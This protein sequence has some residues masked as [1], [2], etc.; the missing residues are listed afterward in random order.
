M[1]TSARPRIFLEIAI[2]AAP[3]GSLEFELFVDA[4]P[5]TCLGSPPGRNLRQSTLHQSAKGV[6]TCTPNSSVPAFEPESTTSKEANTKGLL[7]AVA[8]SSHF[9]ITLGPKPDSKALIFGHMTQGGELL[10]RMA[11]TNTLISISD[12][13]ECNS[14]PVS[15]TMGPPVDEER[16]RLKRRRQSSHSPPRAKSPSR[17]HE[18][19][20]GSRYRRHYRK[21]HRRSSSSSRSITPPPSAKKSRRRSDAELDHN[22][23]GRA[24]QRSRSRTGSPIFESD[25]AEEEFGV[26]RGG[27]KRSP[28]PSRHRS[29]SAVDARRQRSLPNLYKKEMARKRD[30]LTGDGNDDGV[31][32]KDNNHP[33]VEA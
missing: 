16:G 22:Q 6:W 23:R 4:A 1:T 10:D 2:D 19:D 12:C 5:N 18:R 31:K 27:R 29:E 25:S 9:F 32:G 28:P 20:S 26:R 21:H 7:C 24:R 8:G 11:T 3:A 33:C 30:S 14:V 13:G 17:G 15:P